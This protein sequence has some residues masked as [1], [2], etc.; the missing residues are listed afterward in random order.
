MCT[1]VCA[2]TYVCMCVCVLCTCSC[3]F[4][5]VRVRVCVY[6]C[7]YVFVLA[8][9]R[10]CSR[11][12]HGCWLRPH[13]GQGQG[14]GG[15]QREKEQGASIWSLVQAA[16]VHCLPCK[17]Q[18][19]KPSTHMLRREAWSGG[20]ALLGWLTPPPS[21]WLTF[22]SSSHS[23]SVILTVSFPKFTA[24][25]PELHLNCYRAPLG[26]PKILFIYSGSRTGCTTL[27]V[28]SICLLGV[29]CYK[30]VSRSVGPRHSFAS[31][32]LITTIPLCV[33]PQATCSSDSFGMSRAC[34]SPP[35][36]SSP[37]NLST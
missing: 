34:K 35:T 18:A 16:K 9:A 1:Y 33:H 20:R 36:G 24:N 27:V 22:P 32:Y 7:A 19:L 13:Q 28:D 29:F 4:V 23:R 26:Q 14:E 8:C 12:A 15:E 6:V 11:F 30:G 25:Y 37:P 17:M 3:V 2:R 31:F 10:H 21:C 5:C